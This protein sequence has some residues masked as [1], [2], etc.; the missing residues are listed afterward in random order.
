MVNPIDQDDI[1]SRV[2]KRAD[3]DRGRTQMKFDGRRF[4]ENLENQG[5]PSY[6][7]LGGRRGQKATSEVPST[8][9]V[10]V[11]RSYRCEIGQP[12]T[13]EIDLRNR[14]RRMNASHDYEPWRWEP[15]S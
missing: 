5:S 14:G 15:V 12:R 11:S 1:V 2:T 7:C 13:L 6:P 8:R 3:I 10:V 9:D 4:G